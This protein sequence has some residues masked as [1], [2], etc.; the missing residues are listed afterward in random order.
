MDLHGPFKGSAFH[1]PSV[2][3]ADRG[4]RDFKPEFRRHPGGCLD[5]CEILPSKPA[6]ESILLV[7]RHSLKRRI[8]ARFAKLWERQVQS[9]QLKPKKVHWPAD[10]SSFIQSRRFG[11]YCESQSPFGSQPRLT[12]IPRAQGSANF[13][14]SV[15]QAP[16]VFTSGECDHICRHEQRINSGDHLGRDCRRAC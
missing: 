9:V 16:D 3:A 15:N 10:P 2:E 6:K 11:R 1:R 4:G 8:R 14:K 7:Q 5:V 12:A 13:S